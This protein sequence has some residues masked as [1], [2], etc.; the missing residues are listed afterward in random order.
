[1]EQYLVL[2]LENLSPIIIG[3]VST[4]LL[5]LVRGLIKKHKDKLGLELTV[6]GED[7]L[8][9]T[10]QQGVALAEQWAKNKAKTL[11][12]GNKPDGNDKLHQAVKFIFEDLERKG[13]RGVLEKEVRD[14]IEAALGFEMIIG[15]DTIIIPED[16]D[17]GE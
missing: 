14:K 1:M 2:A 9:S 16:I 7:L 15:K 13:V 12:E 6:I 10:V 5:V 11:E 3:V 8:N 4:A 17:E